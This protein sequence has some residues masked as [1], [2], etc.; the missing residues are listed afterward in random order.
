MMPV[1]LPLQPLSR[2]VKAIMMPSC[3]QTRWYEADFVA[4][5]ELD[6]AL[7]CLS[8]RPYPTVHTV[9]YAVTKLILLRFCSFFWYANLI[10]LLFVCPSVL[11]LPFI[12]SVFFPPFDLRRCIYH[13][14]SIFSFMFP[15][16]DPACS[17]VIHPSTL[18]SFARLPSLTRAT[19]LSHRSSMK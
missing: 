11:T 12:P 18:S 2:H 17:S 3:L 4:I 13:L 5:L 9:R 16:S 6:F 8:I 1:S 19:L 10:L 7:M 14:I 15:P